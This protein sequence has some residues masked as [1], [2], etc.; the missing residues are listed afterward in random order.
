MVSQT[1]THLCSDVCFTKVLQ[2]RHYHLTSVAHPGDHLLSSLELDSWDIKSHSAQELRILIWAS[3]CS[4]FVVDLC[5]NN[6]L[7][8]MR[9]FGFS[10]CGSCHQITSC[11]A[12]RFQSFLAH[13]PFGCFWGSSFLF[14]RPSKSVATTGCTLKSF[15]LKSSKVFCTENLRVYRLPMVIISSPMDG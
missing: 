11:A 8:F 14:Y 13:A 12:Q 10:V 2:G 6:S 7:G 1:S 5:G 3:K 4:L 9:L 15:K